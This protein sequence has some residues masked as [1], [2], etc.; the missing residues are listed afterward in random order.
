MPEDVITLENENKL[1]DIN[2]YQQKKTLAQGMLDLALLTANA[3]QLRY[4][5][6]AGYMHEYYYTNLTLIAASVILQISVGMLLLWNSTFN[7]NKQH[8]IVPANT[9]N[10]FTTSGIFLI[11]VINVFISA[12]GLPDRSMVLSSQIV[13]KGMLQTICKDNFE[14]QTNATN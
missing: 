13:T 14:L 5:I 7:I 1:P 9:I 2:V 12:F 8:H 10:N 4:V 6:D 3:N 11:T